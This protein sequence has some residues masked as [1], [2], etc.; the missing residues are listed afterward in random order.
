MLF[1][2]MGQTRHLF[3][4]KYG[5]KF[6]QIKVYLGVLGIRTSYRRIVEANES[7]EL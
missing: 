2:N 7:P 4:Y 1:L 5:T 6:D 3:L